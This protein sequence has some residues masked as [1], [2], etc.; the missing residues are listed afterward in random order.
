MAFIEWFNQ[1]DTQWF[2]AL[3]GC[4]NPFFDRFFTLFTSKEVWFPLYALL[5]VVFIE[6]YRYQGVWVILFFVL[7][8]VLSDQLSGLVKDLVQRFRPTH[9]PALNG[10]VHAPSGKGGLYG[11]VSSHAANSFA[12]TFLLGFMVRRK[13]VWIAFLLWAILAS[14]SRIYV[15][16]HYPLDVLL[17]AV[18]G[19]LIG[20][21]IYHL[22]VA[23]DNRFQRKK[24]FKD[25]NWK[26][27]NT[28]P[29]L[30]ALIFIT[31]TLLVVAQILP[32][33]L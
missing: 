30:I 4:H 23:F 33:Y 28:R 31:V 5:L 1:I 15:G 3:N 13:R 12:L 14:Y 2:L 26:L 21:G 32:K 16:V 7:A 25:G 19:G 20:W 6:K 18:L 24:I 22:L 9:Q 8:I 10:L 17:G 27:I 29:I 11:F